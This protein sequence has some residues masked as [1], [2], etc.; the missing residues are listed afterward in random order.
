MCDCGEEYPG[1]ISSRY[2]SI[3]E[4]GGQIILIT[5][6]SD[7]VGNR[8]FP[9]T[10]YTGQQRDLCYVVHLEGIDP[11]P[12]AIEKSYVSIV[13]VDLVLI[14]EC[15]FSIRKPV[16]HLDKSSDSLTRGSAMILC[17]KD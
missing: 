2:L 8:S 3:E 17:M 16:Q 9:S 6:E 5:A 13:Q 1:V 11:G 14:E 10:C 4:E 15:T 12:E 7:G